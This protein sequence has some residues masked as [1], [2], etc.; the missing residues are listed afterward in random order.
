MNRI[1]RAGALILALCCLS[2]CEK[3]PDWTAK[4]KDWTARI[5]QALDREPSNLS[6]VPQPDPTQILADEPDSVIPPP[7]EPVKMESTIN[8][9]ARVSILGY[10]D[11]TEGRS[12]DDM[13]IN[14]DDF[15]DQMQAIKDSEIP[16]ISMSEYLAWRKGESDIPEQCLMITIDDGWKATHTL[17]MKVLKEF[18]YPFTLFLYQK[19]VGVGGRSLTF[20]EIRELMAAGCEIGSHSVSHRFLTRPEGRGKEAHHAWIK[21][22]MEDSIQFLKANF[23]D[24]GNVLEIL[25]YPYGAYNDK[26]VELAKKCSLEACFT[27]NGKKSEWDESP[28]EVG[29]YIVY[30]TTGANFDFALDFGGGSVASSG[31]KLM[32]ETKTETGQ[33]QGPLVSTWP[34]EGQ[35]IADRLPEI[36]VDLSKLSGVAPDS[37]AVRVTG[38]GLVSHHYDPGS[39][40]VSYQIPQRIRSESCG[41]RVS[42]RHSGNSDTEIIAWNFSINHMAEYLPGIQDAT[43]EPEPGETT[44][45]SDKADKPAR[46]TTTAAVMH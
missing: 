4:L 46:K 43:P 10:H 30:G 14:I 2:S 5:G 29:R 12:R 39:G 17:A 9:E 41:V 44:A 40:M 11:F 31:K 7:P 16:V 36:Q 25:A 27:V 1:T 37:I 22:E 38:F 26:V 6:G 42:F 13:K 45:E 34:A 19:Y 15:R 33:I 8:K 3:A 28:L 32:A 23:G 24:Y 35:S 21:A 18:E 20:E